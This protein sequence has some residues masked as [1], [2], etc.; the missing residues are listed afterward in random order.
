MSSLRGL[1][2]TLVVPHAVRGR[3]RRALLV[4]AGAGAGGA[5]AARALFARV[6]LWQFRRDLRALNRGDYEPVLSHYAEDA[7]LRFNTGAHR[8]S[9]EHSG[10]PAVARFLRNFVH[11][12]LEGQIEEVFF[13]GPPWR[14]RI[15]ARARD[16]ALDAVGTE[17]YRNHV[18]LLARTRWGRIVLHDDFYEDTQRIEAFERRLAERGVAPVD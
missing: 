3:E 6:L 4:A 10:K 8:W 1:R 5:I 13:A 17:L 7:L 2:R 12:G 15:A 18:I 11:A 9:G 16:H 14:L